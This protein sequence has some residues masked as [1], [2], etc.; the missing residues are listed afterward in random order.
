MSTHSASYIKEEYVMPLAVQQKDAKKLVNVCSVDSEV[1]LTPAHLIGDLAE[2]IDNDKSSKKIKYGE[3]N[4]R[5]NVFGQ[6]IQMRPKQHVYV[7][8]EED[9][10]GYSLANCTP[11]DAT[12]NKVSFA[13]TTD[14]K[15]NRSSIKACCNRRQKCKYLI[16]GF[17]VGA[18]V[19]GTVGGVLYTIQRLSFL[20]PG[21]FLSK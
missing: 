20:V 18:L 13:P 2:D 5:K 7:Q 3:D 10:Y 19:A 11:I 16:A 17:I 14:D 4:M 6:N 8:D 15:K 1:Y 9:E 21:N 12:Q